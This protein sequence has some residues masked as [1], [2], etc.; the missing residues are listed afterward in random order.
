[1]SL[2]PGAAEHKGRS[3]ASELG[4]PESSTGRKRVEGW[5]A[6]LRPPTKRISVSTRWRWPPDH[7]A[8]FY[9][10][11]LRAAILAVDV[12]QP[13]PR[14]IPTAAGSGR[15]CRGDFHQA[16][17]RRGWSANGRR[18]GGSTRRAGGGGGSDGRACGVT[19]ADRGRT[20]RRGP[21]GGGVQVV[22]ARSGTGARR[23][24]RTRA[25]RA[26]SR[27]VDGGCVGPLPEQPCQLL[28][29][30]HE[31]HQ[32]TQEGSSSPSRVWRLAPGALSV[33]R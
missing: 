3:L 15:G 14:R 23:T 4:R 11:P 28:V 17:A 30:S 26:R 2:R 24:R 1:M 16:R 20:C 5:E 21:H 19:R 8:R 13:S 32:C 31:G 9:S 10:A 22:D 18:R 33:L 12:Y 29:L 7:A 6:G 27:R 25:W